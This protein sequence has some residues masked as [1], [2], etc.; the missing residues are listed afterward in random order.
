M[1]QA[2]GVRGKNVGMAR[3][4]AN[5]ADPNI[6][7]AAR[8]VAVRLREPLREAIREEAEAVSPRFEGTPQEIL[9][10]AVA[11]IVRDKLTSDAVDPIGRELTEAAGTVGGQ[12]SS[13]Y[14]AHTRVGELAG[15]TRTG[16][17]YSF[18]RN[19]ERITAKAA[20]AE[21]RAVPAPEATGT[22]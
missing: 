18:G 11:L 6:E 20:K 12:Y 13:E 7:D 16:V 17:M 19:R 21:G 22:D 1:L 14:A 9:E 10:A 4:R 2:R 5:T 15:G 3:K 8:R